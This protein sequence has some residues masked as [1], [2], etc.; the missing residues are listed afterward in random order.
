MPMMPFVPWTHRRAEATG[1][2]AAALARLAGGDPQALEALYRRESG[3]VYRYALAL[4]GNPAWAA[5]ATQDAFIAPVQRP[6]RR[7]RPG[8]VTRPA[9][10]PAS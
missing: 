5:D 2:G 8:S 7:P 10:P 6:Q 3:P 1:D 9:S 4:C